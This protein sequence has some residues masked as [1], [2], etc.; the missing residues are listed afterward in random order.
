MEHFLL[1][2]FTLLICTKKILL[3]RLPAKAALCRPPG[4][5]QS[6]PRAPALKTAQI[7]ILL[8]GLGPAVRHRASHPMNRT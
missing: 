4:L 2:D 1:K 8:P 3:H 5:K 6:A 7:S